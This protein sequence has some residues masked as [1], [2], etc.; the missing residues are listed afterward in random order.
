MSN[1]LVCAAWPAAPGLIPVRM[2]VVY[3]HVRVLG[4][5]A[6]LLLLTC[7][8]VVPSTFITGS[9]GPA[10]CLTPIIHHQLPP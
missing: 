4:E 10:L 7:A 2:P 6:P 1:T 9:Q 3:T 5:Q 8:V